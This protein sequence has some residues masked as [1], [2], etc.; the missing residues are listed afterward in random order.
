ME[1]AHCNLY[2]LRKFAVLWLGFAITKIEIHNMLWISIISFLQMR[3]EINKE[4]IVI[5][6]LSGYKKTESLWDRIINHKKGFPLV[7][8]SSRRPSS[9]CQ[10]RTDT[11]HRQA[12]RASYNPFIGWDW[13]G[14]L[15]NPLTMCPRLQCDQD[16]CSVSSGVSLIIDT[17]D[18]LLWFHNSCLILISK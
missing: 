13:G 4:T 1:L 14:R 7:Q 17:N 6:Y 5:H 15:G 9:S 18:Y 12:V 3:I 2:I 16:L 8:S 10:S 11:G